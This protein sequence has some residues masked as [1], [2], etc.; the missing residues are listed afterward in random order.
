MNPTTDL[1][2]RF[3]KEFQ[4]HVLLEDGALKQWVLNFILSEISKAKRE[5]RERERIKTLIEG[6]KLASYR[7]NEATPF[8]EI[9]K[10]Y[11]QALDD[12]LAS[13]E[14]DKEKLECAHEYK[15]TSHTCSKCNQHDGFNRNCGFPYCKCSE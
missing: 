14:E 7:E 10:A 2:E 15:G 12:V 3:E 11:N 4:G 8:A 1:K 5:E 13:L 6:R 9:Y